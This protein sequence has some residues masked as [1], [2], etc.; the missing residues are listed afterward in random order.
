MTRKSLPALQHGPRGDPRLSDGYEDFMAAYSA[1]G[2]LFGT[3]RGCT[4]KQYREM[5]MR[6]YLHWATTRK[7]PTKPRRKQ[8]N[9]TPEEGVELARIISTPQQKDESF[10]RFTTLKDACEARPRAKQ[11]ANKSRATNRKLHNWLI[12]NV[13]T[14]KYRADDVAPTL[15]RHTRTRRANCADIWAGRKPWFFRLS[16]TAAIAH[17]NDPVPVANPVLNRGNLVDVSFD[18]DWYGQFCFMLDATSFCDTMDQPDAHQSCYSSTDQVYPP[19]LGAERPSISSARSIMVYHL[20]HKHG[21]TLVGP[22]VMLTGTRL[23]QSTMSK[24]EQLAQEGVQTWCISATK[25]SCVC[26]VHHMI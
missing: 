18:P 4:K 24:S 15:C 8:V 14:L 16:H 26:C 9:L 11:L 19:R 20:I 6:H 5:L 1:D 13:K 17:E 7:C 2:I 10:E 22:D 25:H 12:R 23:K 21:G 3:N